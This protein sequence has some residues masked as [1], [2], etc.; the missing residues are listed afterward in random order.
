MSDTNEVWTKIESAVKG[1]IAVIILDDIDKVLIKNRNEVYSL[2]YNFARN[3][4]I[5]LIGI[6][7]KCDI[8]WLITNARD[9]CGKQSNGYCIT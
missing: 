8:P 3:P 4:N 9:Q 1:Q 6:I 7:N 5:C 2:I